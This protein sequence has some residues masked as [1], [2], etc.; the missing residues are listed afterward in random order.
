MEIDNFNNWTKVGDWDGHYRFDVATK[1][2]Y[3]IFIEYYIPSNL[4]NDVLTAKASLC[5]VGLWRNRNINSLEREWIG[6]HLPIQELLE[7][8]QED[9]N[10]NMK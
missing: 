9:Y 1:V 2:A 5:V 8:A 3:E 10:K 4:K 7:I 6:K